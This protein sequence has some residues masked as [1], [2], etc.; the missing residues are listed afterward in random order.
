MQIYA[1]FPLRL[2]EQIIQTDL[3][4]YDFCVGIIQK[5]ISDEI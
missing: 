4:L 1:H 3:V 5:A 2:I